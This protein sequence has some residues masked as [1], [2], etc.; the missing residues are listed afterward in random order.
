MAPSTLAR[1]KDFI[2]WL[3]V[4]ASWW[5]D[6]SICSQWLN[7]RLIYSLKLLS[8]SFRLIKYCEFFFLWT[9]LTFLLWHSPC[10]VFY[11]HF[12][13]YLKKINQREREIYLR[14]FK[15]REDFKWKCL[16]N[17]GLSV[18][19]FVLLTLIPKNITHIY[20]HALWPITWSLC[21]Y[22]IR[23]IRIDLSGVTRSNVV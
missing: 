11:D 12:L 20:Q 6:R 10:E 14:Y 15:N 23:R 19:N 18:T 4:S 5:I 7:Y 3:S 9:F 13:I 2:Y 21:S 8:L 17:Y 22:E 16:Y 1:Y